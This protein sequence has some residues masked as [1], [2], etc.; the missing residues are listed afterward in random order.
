MEV[1]VCDA[2]ATRVRWTLLLAMLGM[3]LVIVCW[4]YMQAII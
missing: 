1:T 2:A 3:G 4:R